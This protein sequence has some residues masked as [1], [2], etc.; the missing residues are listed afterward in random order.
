MSLT[1]QP[2]SLARTRPSTSAERPAWRAQVREALRTTADLLDFVGLPAGTAAASP[3]LDFPLM[4]PQAFARRMRRADP[5]DPLLLQV[6]PDPDERRS[7]AGFSADPVGDLPSRRAPG[8]LHKYHGRLL[9]VV[10]GACAVHCRYC[11]RQAFPYAGERAAGRKWREAAEYLRTASDV[12]EVILS[13]GDPLMLP[14]SQL[15]ALSEE[16]GQFSNIK[17]LRLHTRM[18]VVL[19]DRVTPRLLHWINDL[20]WPLV[21]VIHANH[22][23]EFDG[24]VDEGITRL[25]HSGAHVLNQAVLLA[26]VNDSVDALVELM[27]RGFDAGVLP[28]Y[29]HQLDRV[30]GSQRFEVPTDTARILTEALRRRLPGYLVPKLVQ[31]L[32]GTPYK[33]PLL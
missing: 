31:E 15:E 20:P 26:G 4:V 17:R 8:L 7:V 3:A 24:E 22:A 9:L 21:V 1:D 33:T 29:L 5:L 10:T 16:L 28:Y 11:F 27:E 14:T 13:G 2:D 23:A 6:L 18:P 25:R 32:P 30:R 12:E 19:P